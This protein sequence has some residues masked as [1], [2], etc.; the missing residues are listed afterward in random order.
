MGKKEFG[1]FSNEGALVAAILEM[2]QSMGIVAERNHTGGVKRA[3]K[4][5]TKNP[6][7]GRPD[8]EGI[9]PP[10][11]VY[12]GVEVK[13]PGKK[14]TFEQREWI[15]TATRAGGLCFVTDDPK[16]CMAIIADFVDKLEKETVFE[17]YEA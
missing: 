16:E 11:G 5:M 15:E 17:T 3:G 7:K 13:M 10:W 2:I 4:G 9:I 12:L 14:P 1:E 8:I 6:R